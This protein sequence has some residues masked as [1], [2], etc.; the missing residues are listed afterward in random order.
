[1][2]RI[3]R[4]RKVELLKTSKEKL[5]FSF[6]SSLTLEIYKIHFIELN[7]R[8]NELRVAFISSVKYRVVLILFCLSSNSL[9]VGLKLLFLKF[10]LNILFAE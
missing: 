5:R 10:C 1:M 9:V 6:F 3:V 7:S 2:S 8:E 4:Q